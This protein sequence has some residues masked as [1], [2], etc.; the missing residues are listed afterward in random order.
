L[1]QTD[2]EPQVRR[3]A[4]DTAEQ[5][6]VRAQAGGAE[7]MT[8]FSELVERYNG[9]LYNF[10]L[11]RLSPAD[12]EDVAQEA[13]IRAWQR[14]GLYDPRYRFSTW[15]FTIATRLAISHGRSSQRLRSLES[16][17]RPG[18]GMEPGAAASGEESRS[19][20][21]AIVGEHLTSD[22]LTA[23]WLRYVEE[24][25]ITE[26]ARVMGRT[27]VGVRVMLFRA[28]NLLADR[29]ALSDDGDLEMK[30]RVRD[31]EERSSAS[32]AMREGADGTT[33]RATRC[34]GGAV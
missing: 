6:A 21:W 33:T 8:A 26:I 11:R 19:R 22:Q 16:S 4:A 23:V 10:L 32:E 5:L 15:L 24:L 28:R 1:A 34:T 27:P 7:A 13:F 3:M 25:T 14:I 9:R 30:P 18:L 12:A 20:M 29:L 31:A 2:R 17:D